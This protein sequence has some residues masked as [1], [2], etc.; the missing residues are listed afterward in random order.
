MTYIDQHHGV[1]CGKKDWVVPRLGWR[2]GA[3]E[4]SDVGEKLEDQGFDWGRLGV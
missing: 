3:V 4:K 1:I 2:G